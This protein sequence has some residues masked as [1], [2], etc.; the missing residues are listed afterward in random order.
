MNTKELNYEAMQAELDS[1]KL[2]ASFDLPAFKRE[3]FVTINTLM[4]MIDEDD[5]NLWHYE[6]TPTL[7]KCLITS[8][9]VLTWNNEEKEE[10]IDKVDTI[11]Y[12]LR[13]LAKLFN[14]NVNENSYVLGKIIKKCLLSDEA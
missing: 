9:Y 13:M 8:G 2:P 14:E 3:L 5:R 11:L 4:D 10:F 12:T 1:Q 7:Y 6:L